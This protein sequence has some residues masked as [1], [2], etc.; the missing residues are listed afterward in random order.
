V[1]LAIDERYRDRLLRQGL[2]EVGDFMA[3]PGDRVIKRLRAKS[4]VTVRLDHGAEPVTCYLKRHWGRL[5]PG[6]VLRAWLSGFSASWGRKE[7]EVIHAFR[8]AGIPTLTPVAAGE[9]GA[10]WRRESFLL[11]EELSGFQSVENWLRARQTPDP[12][13]T[14]AMIAHVAALTRRLH[15]SGFN[16]RDLYLCHIFVR[17]DASEGWQWRVLDLQ[18]VDRRRWFRTRWIV[19]DLAALNYSAPAWITTR[20]RLR[21]LRLYLGA[22]P[23]RTTLR[24]LIRSVTRKTERIRRHDVRRAARGPTPAIAER[25]RA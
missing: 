7:W 1:W 23:R 21:F 16:H 25:R 8:A 6:D 9:R 4:I 10:W 13:E 19:K 14:R 20:D 24:G 2:R 17:F 12:A 11:T 5:R 3:C 18:R 22:E 15:A